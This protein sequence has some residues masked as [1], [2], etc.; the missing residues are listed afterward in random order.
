MIAFPQLHS[1]V[2]AHDHA[3]EFR[4]DVLE[5]LS[6]PAKAIPAKYLYDA[7]GSRLFDQICELPEYYLTRNESRILATHVGEIRKAGARPLLLAL[8]LFGWLVVGGA[9][10]NRWLPAA[11]AWL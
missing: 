6:R 1:P 11:L 5:G 10:V 9:L 7:Q 2:V 3:D 8:A 4:R